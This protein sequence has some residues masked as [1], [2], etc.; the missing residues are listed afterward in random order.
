MT[1]K[2]ISFQDLLKKNV[3]EV[4][5]IVERRK[6]ATVTERKRLIKYYQKALL[7]RDIFIRH[8]QQISEAYA[9]PNSN[10]K[11]VSH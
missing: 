9:K 6:P 3:P 7:D 8:E 2:N 4:A 1:S 10:D 5:R 11:E